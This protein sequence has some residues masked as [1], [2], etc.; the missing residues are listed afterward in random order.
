MATTSLMPLHVGKERDAKQA[1]RSII[2]YVNNPDKT[3][4]GELVTGYECAPQTFEGQFILARREYLQTTG[5]TPKK[6]DVI[7][8]HLR[9]SLAPGEITPEEAN[10]IGQELAE[11]F[12]H[13]HH[14]FIVATHTDKKHVH[15]HIIWNAITLDCD[16]KF[17]NF[18]GKFQK[19]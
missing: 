10:R 19:G 4:N 9:Q 8:Y 3:Q 1:I 18:W 11:Q 17:R 7:A 2:G 6:S 16:R 12:T 14:A 13:G 15:N 5:R